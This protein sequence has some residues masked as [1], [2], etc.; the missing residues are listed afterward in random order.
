MLYYTPFIEHHKRFGSIRKN[1]V[2]SL[3]FIIPHEHA[4]IRSTV[5]VITNAET[6]TKNPVTGC[7][8]ENPK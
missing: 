5:L 3:V 1:S 4:L 2:C 8:T 7:A 6:P